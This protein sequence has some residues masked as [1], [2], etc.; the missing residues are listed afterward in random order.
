MK[1]ADAIE[2]MQIIAKYTQDQYCL[3][4]EH[5]QVFCGDYNL[6]LTPEERGRLEELGWFE[7]AGSWSFYT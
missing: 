1:L 6:P 3:Q 5:D 7:E 4:G 2:G